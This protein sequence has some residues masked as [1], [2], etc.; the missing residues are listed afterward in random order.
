MGLTTLG[1][2]GLL[3]GV[4]PGAV[5]G[6]GPAATPAELRVEAGS[7]ESSAPALDTT[8]DT[9]QQA[10]PGAFGR[11]AAGNREGAPIEARDLLVPVSVGLLFAG[12]G[13]T[14]ARRRLDR[15]QGN[16]RGRRVV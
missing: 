5:P 3:I 11:P 12:L 1:L 15:S 8:G 9:I 10:P 7:S 4:V 6:G 13:I 14:V 2:A 16:H